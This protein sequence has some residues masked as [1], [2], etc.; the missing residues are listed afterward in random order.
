MIEGAAPFL[1]FGTSWDRSRNFT[2]NGALN[3]SKG[4]DHEDEA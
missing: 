1:F 3:G 4:D 2:G